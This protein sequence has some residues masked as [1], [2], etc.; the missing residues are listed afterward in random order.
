MLLIAL[1]DFIEFV[2][3]KSSRS[4]ISHAQF[5][6]IFIPSDDVANYIYLNFKRRTD[7]L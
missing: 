4:C 3:R 6:M 5:E 1:E 2:R 7:V